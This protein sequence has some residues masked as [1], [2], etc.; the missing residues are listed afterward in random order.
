MRSVL[1]IAGHR[2]LAAYA[3]TPFFHLTALLLY[4]ALAPP[5]VRKFARSPHCYKT[6]AYIHT[7]VPT[8]GGVRLS[9]N[10]GRQRPSFQ[11]RFG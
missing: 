1:A 6:D 3:S 7:H 5:S 9:R 10:A 8:H 2:V 11:F 4:H